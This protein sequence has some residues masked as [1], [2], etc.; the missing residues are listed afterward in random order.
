MGENE[1][2]HSFSTLYAFM[3][4]LAVWVLLPLLPAILTFRLFP[5]TSVAVSGPFANLTVRA[6]GA[7]AAYLIVF[8]A[9]Y[10]FLVKTIRDDI[11]SWKAPHQFWTVQIP[12]EFIGAD[13]NRI[14]NKNS[15]MNVLSNM[16]VETRPDQ[17]EF[18]SG[19]ITL[20][21]VPFE[22]GRLPLVTLKINN[23]VDET[24]DLA[25]SQLQKAAKNRLFLELKD[26]IQIRE[27]QR[28][29]VQRATIDPA[30]SDEN[31]SPM[32]D[33]VRGPRPFLN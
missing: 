8:A 26:K 28:R 13:G 22:A 27:E 3:G 32:D 9:T 21:I 18:G 2:P 16:K 4:L 33:G 23:F 11:D 1:M 10:F 12:V 29:E 5:Q 17:H 24:I 30:R 15:I 31:S 6:G 7:F 14:T 20:R 25:D 19:K